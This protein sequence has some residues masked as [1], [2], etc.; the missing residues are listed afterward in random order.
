MFPQFSTIFFSEFIVLFFLVHLIEPGDELPLMDTVHQLRNAF[1]LT[2]PR[3]WA[4]KVLS[5][6]KLFKSRDQKWSHS[7][8]R[9]SG[10]LILGDGSHAAFVPHNLRGTSSPCSCKLKC[11]E[12]GIMIYTTNTNDW[13]VMFGGWLFGWFVNPWVVSAMAS[14]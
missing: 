3:R 8:G 5:P 1:P 13:G 4:P 10:S 12:N 9:W 6:A 2:R 14:V 7:Q 11:V